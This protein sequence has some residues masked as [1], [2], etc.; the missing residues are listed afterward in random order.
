MDKPPNSNIGSPSIGDTLF[1]VSAI[2]V[3]AI[4]LALNARALAAMKLAT[5]LAF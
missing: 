1:G 4:T 3:I 5:V 2:P